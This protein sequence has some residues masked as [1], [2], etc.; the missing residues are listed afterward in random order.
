M[1]L[2]AFEEDGK[3]VLRW[4]KWFCEKAWGEGKQSQAQCNPHTEPE[5][6]YSTLLQ[7]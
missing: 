4:P 2:C 6:Q 1:Q 5:R 7:S 3:C